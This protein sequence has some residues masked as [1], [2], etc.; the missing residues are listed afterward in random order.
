MFYALV[1]L[2][3]HHWHIL[4]ERVDVRLDVPTVGILFDFDR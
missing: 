2:N 3:V 1:L 4:G